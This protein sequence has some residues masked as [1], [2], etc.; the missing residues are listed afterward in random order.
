MHIHKRARSTNQLDEV[1]NR[2]YSVNINLIDAKT[3]DARQINPHS[4]PTC[5]VLPPGEF[6]SMI[7]ELVLSVL[8]FSCR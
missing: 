4:A 6:N 3:S 7:T 8:K 5:R 2:H 1:T